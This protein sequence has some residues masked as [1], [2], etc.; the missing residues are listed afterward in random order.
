MIVEEEKTFK[1][2]QNP[3]RKSILEVLSEKGK[4][5]ATEI[6]KELENKEKFE[7]THTIVLKHLRELE[8]AKIVKSETYRPET[9]RPGKKFYIDKEGFKDRQYQFGKLKVTL[10]ITEDNGKGNGWNGGGK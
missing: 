1:A 8:D 10:T 9:G 2:L 4:Q 3:T 6:C 7:I 5:S